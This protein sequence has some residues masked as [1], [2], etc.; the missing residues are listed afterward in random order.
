MLMCC[1]LL[2]PEVEVADPL[3]VH[4]HQALRRLRA[5]N[6]DPRQTAAPAG[7]DDL[8][9][10][11]SAQQIGDAVR[12]QAI[13]VVAGEHRIGC[14]A[15]VARFYLAVG[16]DQYVGQFQGLVA[17]EGVGQQLAGWQQ[18]QRQGERGKFHGQSVGALKR[19]HF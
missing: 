5:A 18:G 7:L 10:G 2:S 14:A 11:H 8:H 16:A 13:D 4:Q 15:V 9:P 6:V 17:F 12:L 3:P 1:R 19:T